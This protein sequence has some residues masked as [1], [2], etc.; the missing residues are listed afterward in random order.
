MPAKDINR[1]RDIFHHRKFPIAHITAIGLQEEGL[2]ILPRIQPHAIIKD[3]PITPVARIPIGLIWA[4]RM[5]EFHIMGWDIPI[6]VN[7]R[8]KHDLV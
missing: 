1:G 8:T 5:T 3:P 4:M 6:P 7:G 2:L